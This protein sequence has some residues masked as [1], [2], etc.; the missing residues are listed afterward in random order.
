M[1]M[2]VDIVFLVSL[3]LALLD[4]FLLGF[5]R[6]LMFTILFI[7]IFVGIYYI[8]K[9]Q[10]V[11]YLRYDLLLDVTKGE[12]ISVKITEEYTV[13]VKSIE[14][15]FIVL[16]NFDAS[17]RAPFLK[18]TCEAFCT[19][20]FFIATYIIAGISSRVLTWVLW[21]LP[22]RWIIPENLRRPKILSR[23]IGA[24]ISVIGCVF[25]FFIV[26]TFVFNL[27]GI[28]AD[29]DQIIADL[30]EADLAQYAEYIEKYAEY[31][32]AIFNIENST[33]TKT[34]FDIATNM[35]LDPYSFF[36]FE[37]EGT[38]YTLYDAIHKLIEPVIDLLKNMNSS[39]SNSAEPA[40]RILV[41]AI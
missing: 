39:D 15:L 30:K 18:G 25:G 23:I 32:K 21:F 1:T 36:S 31:I 3:V 40:G 10:V 4:G 19:F 17:L 2:I 11:D 7:G 41:G 35:G 14:D 28:T 27:G 20:A 16:Q 24:V 29:L 12:G 26:A 37:A 22:V 13:I 5:T 6:R 38:T 34:L 9:A 8:A 33:V